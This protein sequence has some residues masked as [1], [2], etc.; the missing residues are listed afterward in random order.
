MNRRECLGTLS[1]LTLPGIISG[2]FTMEDKIQ[3]RSIPTT[4]EQLPVV[5]LGTWQTFDVSEQDSETQPLREVLK[6]L[7]AKG[8]TVVDSS[9]M[10]GR[11]EA[12]VGELS[13]ELSLNSSLFIATKVWTQGRENGIRQMNESMTLLRRKKIDLMQVHNLTDWQTHLKTLQTWKDSTCRFYAN[14]L[15]NPVALCRRTTFAARDGEECRCVD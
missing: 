11:S 10:Y 4:G 9:P 6:T 13:E 15:F 14:Q 1:A 12:V 2:G 5:G 3:R 8:G 7:V